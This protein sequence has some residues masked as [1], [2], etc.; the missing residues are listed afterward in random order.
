MLVLIQLLVPLLASVSAQSQNA[1]F[2]GAQGIIYS[3]GYPDNYANQLNQF[4][5]ISVDPGYYIHLTLYDFET[6]ACCDKLYIWNGY[7]LHQPTIAKFVYSNE[8]FH[9][10]KVN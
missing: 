10:F 6:E 9:S 7:D 1:S 8:S 2:S 4:Y 5:T 3:P